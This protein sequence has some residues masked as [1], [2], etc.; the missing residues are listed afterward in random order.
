[1]QGLYNILDPE[2]CFSGLDQSRSSLLARKGG[3]GGE[4][5]DKLH[6]VFNSLF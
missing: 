5:G 1:M 6:S 4:V 3:G 2:G